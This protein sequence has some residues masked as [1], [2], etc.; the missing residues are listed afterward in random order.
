[1]SWPVGGSGD[2]DD[3]ED[4]A[5]YADET[6]ARR[7]VEVQTMNLKAGMEALGSPCSRL[8]WLSLQACHGRGG[9][10]PW[11]SSLRREVPNMP[12]MPLARRS[13]EK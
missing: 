3:I 12:S 4:V 6:Y 2:D 7:G 1:M 5:M 11:S 10:F 13:S 8:E 9:L